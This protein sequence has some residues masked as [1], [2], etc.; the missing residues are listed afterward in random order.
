MKTHTAWTVFGVLLSILRVN[1]G[2]WIKGD[3]GLTCNQVC[4]ALG[5]SC[6]IEVQSTIQSCDAVTEAFAETGYTCASCISS[7]SYAGTPFSTAR[8]GDDC[9]PLS[10]GAESVCNGN[11]YGHH[12]AL[13]YCGDSTSG[14]PTMPV[15][16]WDFEA[17]DAGTTV[18][19]DSISGYANYA[20]E[21]MDTAEITSEGLNCN[22]GYARTV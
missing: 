15:L 14:D 21:L 1:A 19:P 3:N 16:F 20:I 17:A 22:G 9:Y 10:S 5:A 4:E 2:E 11:V 7:R 13:C 8:V 18:I 12:S 6:N